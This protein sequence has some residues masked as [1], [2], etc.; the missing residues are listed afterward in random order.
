MCLCLMEFSRKQTLRQN[1]TDK[2]YTGDARQWKKADLHREESYCDAGP[3]QPQKEL[4]GEDWP[5]RVV[6]HRSSI[7]TL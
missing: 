7:R 2:L 1:V 5:T 6:L 4:W 3:Q